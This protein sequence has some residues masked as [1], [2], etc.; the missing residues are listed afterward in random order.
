MVSNRVNRIILLST[1]LRR[2]GLIVG[3]Q[4]LLVGVHPG[5]EPGY[6]E[7]FVETSR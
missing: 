4:E 6:S 7:L 2:Q 1:F 3:R 5:R